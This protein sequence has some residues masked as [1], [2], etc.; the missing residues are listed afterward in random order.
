LFLKVDMTPEQFAK[1]LSEYLHKTRTCTLQEAIARY[2][3]KQ[4]E[5]VIV[6]PIEDD[7]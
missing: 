1:D 5:W 2:L 6:Q 7:C 3:T 4:K